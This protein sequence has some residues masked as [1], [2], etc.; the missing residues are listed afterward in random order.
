M[1]PLI[2]K[3]VMVGITENI[4]NEDSSYSNKGILISIADG[5][6]TMK[7]DCSIISYPI[8]KINFIEEDTGEDYYIDGDL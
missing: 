7:D 8:T 6:L 5:F 2:N 1:H 3:K 4:N